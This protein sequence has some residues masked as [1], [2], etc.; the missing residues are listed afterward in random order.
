[1]IP[2]LDTHLHLIYQ[3][4]F[5]YKWCKDVPALQSDFN[6]EEYEQITSKLGI[7]KS[8]FMEVDVIEAE[9]SQEASFFAELAKRN[10][11]NLSGI[12]ASCRPENE[13]FSSLLDQ[14][15]SELVC[16]FRRVLHVMPDALS[17]SKRF[18]DNIKVIASHQLPFE[19][20]INQSQHQLIYDL[21]HSCPDNQFVL[22]HCG[23][24]SLILEDY[25]PWA[26]SLKKIASLPNVVCKISGI[27]AGLPQSSD[28]DTLNPWIDT[29]L[30]FFGADKVMIGS[31]W[32]VCNLGRDLPTWVNHIRTQFSTYSTSEQH[33]IFHQNA[34]SIYQIQ[35]L[36]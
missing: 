25:K 4:H 35:N 12:I 7:A 19:L 13:N 34:Q 29:T 32:P 1:M 23:G 2:I 28:T 33:K 18:R 14:T 22:D 5:T 6:I 17:Q 36:Q 30:E 8:I 24:P 3:N 9:I 31:D 10:D 26:A 27:I 21:I 11:N 15:L 16:G 20:C